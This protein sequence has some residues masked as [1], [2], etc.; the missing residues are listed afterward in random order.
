[1]A[2]IRKGIVMKKC[3]IIIFLP[4]FLYACAEE[5]K[6]DVRAEV[7]ESR[8]FSSSQMQKVEVKNV[9]GSVESSVWDD[10]SIHVT[11][12]KWAT[13]DDKDDARENIDD[14]E[15]S[16]SEDTASGVLR[17]DVDMPS[18]YAEEPDYGCNVFL[19]LPSS[20]S[21]DLESSN[22]DIEIQGTEANAVLET[23][24]GE[25]TAKNHSGEL[26]GLTSNGEIDVDIALPS[27]G[28]CILKTSN[29]DIT[30][31]ISNT[32]SATIEASTSNGEVEI[33]GLD[34]TETER[35]KTKFMG[36]MGDGEGVI[37]LQTSN[38]NIHIEK[39]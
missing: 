35:K 26:S 31:S 38:G 1:M 5:D 19:N 36:T 34:V 11:F 14:I 8:D 17:I 21:L 25:I 7:E 30:L 28:E 12:E 27:Q 13:G 20:L 37:E 33:K 3:L 39:R 6:D 32:T 10:D 16:I 4:F 29:G 23:S 18:S 9:N 22:G 24:N 15:I 2:T